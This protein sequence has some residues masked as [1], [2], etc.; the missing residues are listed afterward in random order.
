[1]NLNDFFTLNLS[2]L[3]LTLFGQINECKVKSLKE[4]IATS[5]VIVVGKL[6]SKISIKG[7]NT[8]AFVISEKFKGIH[9]NYDIQIVENTET[10]CT[11]N[12]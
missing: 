3:T 9:E 10:M 4:A 2:L 11:I 12:L 6:G 8:Y 1:M 5:D 7:V